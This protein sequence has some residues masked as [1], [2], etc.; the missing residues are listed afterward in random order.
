MIEYI[1]NKI[2]KNEEPEKVKTL[3]QILIYIYQSKIK[4]KVEEFE[5]YSLL[6][7]F[8]VVAIDGEPDNKIIKNNIVY[9]NLTRIYCCV[10][11][12]KFLEIYLKN[13]VNMEINILIVKNFY[14]S[15]D[16]FKEL[17]EKIK[18]LMIKILFFNIFKQDYK[19]LEDFINET[20]D[21]YLTNFIGEDYKNYESINDN[22]NNLYF[23]NIKLSKNN[24]STL[25]SQRIIN[26]RN[27]FKKLSPINQILYY[28]KIN[29]FNKNKY[30]SM[31][32]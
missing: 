7:K 12:E 30:N 3:I 9:P 17:S 21:D 4:I 11:M 13:L 26:G 6:M 25:L 23:R 18:E 1:D 2:K 10:F 5:D 20:K 19:K 8:I 32:K 29:H 14:H 31:S 15:L 28:K 22:C 24:S 16:G 27:L